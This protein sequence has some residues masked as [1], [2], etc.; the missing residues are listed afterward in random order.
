MLVNKTSELTLDALKRFVLVDGFPIIIDFQAS[1]GSLLVDRDSRK[2]YVDMYAFTSSNALGFNHP[3]MMERGFLERLGRASTM[4]PCNRDVYTEEHIAFILT[5]A[6]ILPPRLRKHIFTIDGGGAL[7]IE[8]ALKAAWDRQ[9]RKN[10]RAGLTTAEDKETQKLGTGVIHFTGAFHGRTGWTTSMT[11]TAAAIKTMWFPRFDWPR[12]EFPVVSFPVEEHR[13][14]IEQAEA[15]ALEA[16]RAVLEARPGHVAAMIL[17]PVQCEGGDRHVRP[18]FLRAL[19][20]VADEFDILLIFD[21]IQ[22]G[23]AVSG[24]WWLHQHYDVEPDILCFA[25]RAQ[26]PGL[27]TNDKV[28]AFAENVFT[29]DSRINSTWNAGQ[30]DFLRATRFIEIVR[31][32]NLL[33]NARR[34]GAYIRQRASELARDFPEMTQVRGVGLLNA[35]DL[36]DPAWRGRLVKACVGN[37]LLLTGCGARSM[38]FRPYLDVKKEEIDLAMTRLRNALA[39]ARKTN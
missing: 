12:I 27:A 6:E 2:E 4:K 3:K 20:R 32:D 13:A 17:E 9:I 11:N 14:R 16:I 15:K 26:V 39:E 7:G 28:D 5:F 21:E 19:R 23:F 24:E 34:M 36:P 37:G 29:I 10:I 33:E 38:R 1:R 30:D 31:E 18:E 35:F 8:N 22:T 25:K